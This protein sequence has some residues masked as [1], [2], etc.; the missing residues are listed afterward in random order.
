M[1]DGTFQRSAMER[2]QGSE[3]AGNPGEARPGMPEELVQLIEISRSVGADPDWVQGGGGNTSVKSSDGKRMFIKAS[4][5]ALAEMDEKRGWAEMDMQ[6]VV[7]LLR[8]PGLDALSSGARESEVLRLLQ[9]AVLRPQGARPSVESSLHALL[10]RV[11][12]HVH[13]VGIN[14]FLCA[15][16]SRKEHSHVLSFLEDPPLY[17][18]YVDPGYTL[19]A[20]MA[21][22]IEEYRS[23]HGKL[24]PVVLL[25]N[26]GVF[27]AAGRSKEC[28]ELAR[29]IVEAGQDWLGGARVNPRCFLGVVE[30]EGRGPGPAGAG[31]LAEL[32]GA[33]LKGGA[34]PLSLRRDE[35]P[36]AAAFLSKPGAIAAA[37]QGAFTPDQIVYSRT[38]PLVL[39][40]GAPEEWVS[41]VS[42]YRSQFGVDPRVVVRMPQGAF[43]GGVYY[44]APDLPQ[45]K[46]VAE[47]YRSAMAAIIKSDAA[48]GPRFLDKR[49]AAFIEGWEV[50]KYRAA[51]LA[52]R[53]A[54]LAGRVAV[55][56]GAASGL[57]KG[58]ALGLTGAGAAVFALD[59]N[60]DAL[61]ILRR[62][63]P[64]GKYLPVIVDVTSE[65]SVAQGFRRIEASAGGIDYLVNAAGIAPPGPLV[66]FP[67]AAWRKT[68]EINLTGYFL[69]AREAARLLLRQGAGGSIVNLTSK[70]GLDASKDNS[71]YNATK[72]GEI[73]LTRGWALEL[74]KAG[75]RVNCVAPGNVFKGSQIWN[76]EYI[77]ACARKKGI[78]PEEVI[79]Y[80]NS[81]TALG[82][83][84]EPQDV[85]DAVIFLLS[86]QARTITGQV[87]VVD[88][89]QVMVR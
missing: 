45:L 34:A 4:G 80:Y 37:R 27:V 47:T 23:R 88:G 10:D 33:L 50:E 87:L 25:E 53:S 17:V 54:N 11:V 65:E 79:P 38:H 42:G 5:T 84:I 24:P 75:I 41:A 22:E 82:R 56:T 66:D 29:A 85:A 62:G 68:L 77:R 48:G 59:I 14:A 46:V 69:C 35:E 78:Q 64:D 63:T 72:A 55:V 15:R 74:G 86:D 19:A 26:H 67:L 81:L 13:A 43:P 32:R 70:S 52:G 20:R 76:E 73:H 31:Q 71:A 89:G 28:M 40:G 44:G 30:V 1:R 8:R 3:G 57:G 6:A 9:A 39:E 51:L 36:I 83:E 18:P 49:Q 16:D 21:R 60:P 2:S 61:E 7:D 12:I 58:I